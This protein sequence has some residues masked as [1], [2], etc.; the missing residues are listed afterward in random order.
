M[1]LQNVHVLSSSGGYEGGR[2]W[3]DLSTNEV[4]AESLRAAVG[5]DMERNWLQLPER[6][7]G[8]RAYSN[9]SPWV[10]PIDCSIVC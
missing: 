10:L 2:S 3:T 4:I 1:I 5:P 9:A 8:Y 7:Y 6:N